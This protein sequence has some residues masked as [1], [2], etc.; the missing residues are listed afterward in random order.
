MVDVMKER[1]PATRVALRG[2]SENALRIGDADAETAIIATGQALFWAC[3]L[4]DRLARNGGYRSDREQDPDGRLLIGLRPARNA[5]AHGVAVVMFPSMHLPAKRHIVV[6]APR[7]AQFSS[8]RA[9]LDKDP[10]AKALSIWDDSLAEKN[11]AATMHVV[12]AWLDAV[13]DRYRDT[14]VSEMSQTYRDSLGE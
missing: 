2:L 9:G 8:V 10:G 12:H 1:D 4:D 6:R 14:L 5:F 3:A 13:V 11:A 7:W